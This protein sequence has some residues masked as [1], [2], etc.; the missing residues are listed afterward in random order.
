MR[1]G[2]RI[3]RPRHLQQMAGA[4]AFDFGQRENS[5]MSTPVTIAEM[6]REPRHPRRLENKKNTGIA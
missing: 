6:T 1:A 5:M 3:D 2:T 4:A